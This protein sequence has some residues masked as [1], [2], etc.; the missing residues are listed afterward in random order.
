M[1]IYGIKTCD[2]CRKAIRAFPY[3]QFIDIR[4]SGLP[5][6]LR[7]RAL[8]EFGEALINR[9]S[10]TW[11]ELDAAERERAPQDLLSDHPV[12]MKRPLIEDDEDGLHLGWTKEVQA[13][14]GV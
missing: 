3:A 8:E 5:D 11:R 7:A 6:A 1:R 14:L 13:A 2:P 12:L 9:R 10:T 4:A